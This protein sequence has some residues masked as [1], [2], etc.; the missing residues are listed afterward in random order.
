MGDPDN[1][2]RAA[3]ALLQRQWADGALCPN[4]HRSQQGSHRATFRG[5]ISGI[6]RT[7]PI[8]DCRYVCPA[9]RITC[10]AAFYA[11][12]SRMVQR[13]TV[14]LLIPHL[15]GGGA[16]HVTALLTRG[17]STRKYE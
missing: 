10:D 12:I 16:E 9:S 11:R 1:D 15:G 6:S 3:V 13:P 2:Q 7:V 5:M 14:L 8:P 17:L 4:R